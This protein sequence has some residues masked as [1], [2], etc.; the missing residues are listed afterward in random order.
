[1]K[2]DSTYTMFMTV[3][4]HLGLISSTLFSIKPFFLLNVTKRAEVATARHKHLKHEAFVFSQQLIV[5]TFSG[6]RTFKPATYQWQLLSPWSKVTAL[7]LKTARFSESSL[8]FYRS[9]RSYVTE[10]TNSQQTLS[11]NITDEHVSVQTWE[12]LFMHFHIRG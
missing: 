4:H 12:T 8:C 6:V 7:M 10:D 3:T 1:M 2:E 9:T 5:K 11:A